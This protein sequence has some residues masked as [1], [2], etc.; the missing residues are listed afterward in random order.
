MPSAYDCS[1]AAIA[2]HAE[3]A[4]VYDVEPGPA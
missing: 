4:V 2:F 1:S 3:A